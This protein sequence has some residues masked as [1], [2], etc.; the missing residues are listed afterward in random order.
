MRRIDMDSFEHY[1]FRKSGSQIQLVVFEDIN[2]LAKGKKNTDYGEG[3]LLAT[4]N[5]GEKVEFVFGAL[6][7]DIDD[8]LVSDS[9]K[10]GDDMSWALSKIGLQVAPGLRE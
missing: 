7:V 3:K 10:C 6:L 1:Q 9:P 2:C 4:F 8:A 5:P